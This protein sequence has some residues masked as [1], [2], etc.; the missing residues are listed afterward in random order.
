MVLSIKIAEKKLN[1]RDGLFNLD[2]I[3]KSLR[4]KLLSMGYIM[5]EKEQEYKTT[6]YGEGVNFKFLY[7][8][9]FDDFAKVDSEVLFKFENL[10]KIKGLHKGDLALTIKPALTLDYKHRWGNNA[11]NKFFFNLYRKVFQDDLKKRYFGNVVRDTAEVYDYIK[12]LL[13][14]YKH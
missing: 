2:N 14:E 5:V 6:Q 8:K 9:A 3:Y 10:K 11:F 4:G 1:L 12:D 7:F 13:D